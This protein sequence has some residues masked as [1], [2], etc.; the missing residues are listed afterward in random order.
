[1]WAAGLSNQLIRAV[2][3]CC[4]WR[5]VL[6]QSHYARIHAQA[7]RACG[8]SSSQYLTSAV[9]ILHRCCY[10]LALSV[11]RAT[12]GRATSPKCSYKRLCLYIMV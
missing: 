4:A 3:H 9:L 7:C 8:A 1:M 2:R 11:D 6:Q 10:D 12:H 5:H